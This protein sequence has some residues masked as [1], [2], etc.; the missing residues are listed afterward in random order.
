MW[1]GIINGIPDRFKIDILKICQKTPLFCVF[2]T[3]I[4]TVFHF[5][6]WKKKRYYHNRFKKETSKFI[7]K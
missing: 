3:I 2:F 6:K 5:I 7:E 4:R 1:S